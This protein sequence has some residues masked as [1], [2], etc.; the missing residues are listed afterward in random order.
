MKKTDIPQTKLFNF[1]QF[2]SKG[3]KRI[4]VVSGILLLICQY[5]FIDVLKQSHITS[6]LEQAQIYGETVA[7][8]VK[9]SLNQGIYSSVILKDLYE[10]YGDNFIKDFDRLSARISSENDSI[11]SIYFAPKGII[12]NAYPQSIRELTIGFNML[13]NE[14]QKEKSLQAIESQHVTIAGPHSLIE[15]GTGIIIRNPLFNGDDFAAFTI[16]VINWDSFGKKLSDHLKNSESVYKFALWKSNDNHAVTDSNGFI[17]KNFEGTISENLIDIDIE[18]P[19]DTWHLTVEPTEGWWKLKD[20]LFEITLSW[21]IVISL[22]LTLFIRMKRN[23]I[24]LYKAEHDELTGLYTKQAFMNK[25]EEL[26]KKNPNKS[27]DIVISDIENFKLVNL[28]YGQDKGD[29]VIKYFASAFSKRTPGALYGRFGGDSL[30]CILPS[31]NNEGEATFSQFVNNTLSEAPVKN[32]KINFGIYTNIDKKLPV[33]LNCDRAH[34]AARSI[35]QNFEKSIA[36][37]NGPISTRHLKEQLLETS[38]DQALKNNEFKIYFQP[39]FDAYTEKLIGAEALVRWIKNDGTMISPV[40]FIELFETDGLII[41]L[42]EYVFTQVCKTIKKW[43]EEG[44]EPV[45]V[46]VNL[47]RTSLLHEGMINK[48][49]AIIKETGIPSYLIPLELTESASSN[50][51]SIRDTS[52]QLKEAGFEIHMDDFGTGFSSLENL[53]ILP[54]DAV[55]LDKSLIDYIGDPG[56]DEIIR[57]TI[58]LAHFKN[59]Y[60]VA[61]GVESRIQLNFLKTLKCDAIQGYLFSRPVPEDEYVKFLAT[62]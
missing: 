48:Y 60:I 52:I 36:N 17:F 8:A 42:D 26:I 45:P 46:S 7:S 58:E 24:K 59:M 40:D 15:G 38:F 44:Y 29:N 51:S 30:V 62:N 61:E 31:S 20:M 55:K 23:S 19:N 3:Q 10:E 37:Y 50:K 6:E 32:L 47:S 14:E 39:K 16:I 54:F 34:L 25:A 56:G 12:Q 11:S 27:F 5:V 1:T 22:M 13:E 18:V 35:K 2:L 33:N 4:L 9:L 53:N 28:L 41:R 57:H 49:K 21:V 43:Q